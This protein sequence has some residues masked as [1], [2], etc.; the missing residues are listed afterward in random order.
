M[1][2]GSETIDRS[3]VS[4]D[5][6]GAAECPAMNCHRGSIYS[7]ISITALPIVSDNFINSRNSAGYSATLA[8]KL[9]IKLELS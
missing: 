6:Q 3:A 4:T 5:G 1:E 8:A 7:N 2:A 9:F